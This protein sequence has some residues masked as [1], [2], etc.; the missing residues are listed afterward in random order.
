MFSSDTMTAGRAVYDVRMCPL[1][2]SSPPSGIQLYNLSYRD[3]GYPTTPPS[4]RYPDL[5]ALDS[6]C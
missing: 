3:R 2:W 4:L 5:L 6:K 1:P